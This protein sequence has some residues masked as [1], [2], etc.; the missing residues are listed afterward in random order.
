MS[1]REAEP[2]FS[3]DIEFL[4]KYNSEAHLHEGKKRCGGFGMVI[5]N[6][7]PSNLLAT[8]NEKK[9]VVRERGHYAIL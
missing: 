3:K 9:T 6:F 4:I 1:L 7:F 2:S 8:L 5:Q